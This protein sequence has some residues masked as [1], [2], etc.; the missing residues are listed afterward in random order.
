M[1]ELDAGRA[2]CVSREDFVDFIRNGGRRQVPPML[3]TLSRRLSIELDDD[4]AEADGPF[5]PPL[6]NP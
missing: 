3:H 4:K 2:G 5:R 1:R 6:R